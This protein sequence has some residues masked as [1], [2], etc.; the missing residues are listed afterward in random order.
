M[1]EETVGRAVDVK[2]IAPS[3]SQ[4]TLATRDFAMPLPL[5]HVYYYFTSG[6]GSC[7]HMFTKSVVMKLIHDP[8]E[9]EPGNRRSAILFVCV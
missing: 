1:I 9:K 7:F 3:A 5:S 4:S 2:E 8:A 6:F